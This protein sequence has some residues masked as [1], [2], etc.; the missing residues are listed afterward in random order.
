MSDFHTPLSG[1]APAFNPKAQPAAMPTEDHLAMANMKQN[2]ARVLRIIDRAGGSMTGEELRVTLDGSM[3]PEERKL[4][5]KHLRETKQVLHHGNTRAVVYTL[6]G[7]KPKAAPEQP[8]QASTAPTPAATVSATTT[9]ER[10]TAVSCGAFFGSSEHE[11]LR[12]SVPLVEG[13]APEI[14]LMAALDHVVASIRSNSS[15][16]TLSIER[17]T[18]WL[19]SKHRCAA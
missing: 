12:M 9:D 3:D 5:V 16:D 14:Q 18:A 11:Q 8:A 2:A 10:P 19:A 7:R 6:P 17:A 1:M 4:A 13:V 15:I